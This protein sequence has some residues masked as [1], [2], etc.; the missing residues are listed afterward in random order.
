MESRVYL[1]L[2][3]AV[4]L[5]VSLYQLHKSKAKIKHQSL[6]HKYKSKH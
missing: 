6:K 3:H 5:T 2:N 4:L 1:G